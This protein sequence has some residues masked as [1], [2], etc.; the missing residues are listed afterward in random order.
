[1]LRNFFYW[2]RWYDTDTITRQLGLIEIHLPSDPPFKT[3]L[4]CKWTLRQW[5]I[6]KGWPNTKSCDNWTF[7]CGSS[8]YCLYKKVLTDCTPSFS[9][10]LSHTR[11][12]CR[13]MPK[14][15][16]ALFGPELWWLLKLKIYKLESSLTFDDLIR[17]W[18]C[19]CLLWLF[20]AN[21]TGTVVRTQVLITCW[22]DVDFGQEKQNPFL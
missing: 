21:I 6:S 22:L 10:I 13:K 19:W 3:H 2:T 20:L 14:S 4:I 7:Y 5:I 12:R 8:F 17:C 9:M 18:L 15:F 16:D 11:V 1:M